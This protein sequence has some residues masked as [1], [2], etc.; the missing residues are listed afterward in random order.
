MSR[1]LDSIDF[2]EVKGYKFTLKFKTQH[3]L[4]ND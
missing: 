2:K 1:F 3:Y 4:N